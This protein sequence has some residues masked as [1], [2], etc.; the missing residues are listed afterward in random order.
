MSH[1]DKAMGP[2]NYGCYTD[3]QN[4][5]GQPDDVQKMAEHICEEG[6]EDLPVK[7]APESA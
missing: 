7:K 2:G 5:Y 1:L 6:F 4:C 3:E